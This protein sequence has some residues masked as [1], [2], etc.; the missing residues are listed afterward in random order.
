MKRGTTFAALIVGAMVLSA[1]AQ[2]QDQQD[3][4]QSQQQEQQ[5]KQD[6]DKDKASQQSEVEREAAGAAAITENKTIKATVEDID[7]E[8][9][10]VT[11][12]GED[13]KTKT[14]KVP[15][16]A[17]NFDQLQKGDHVTAK[18]AEAI[19]IGVRKADEPPSAEERQTV[20][21]TKKGEK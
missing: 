14:I 5:Q 12:K 19:A 18:Y 1:T 2:Q 8:K 15:E 7:R 16:E 3:S 9:R 13:G 6:Q 11:L 20:Y 17:R 21:G 10:E 4:Q